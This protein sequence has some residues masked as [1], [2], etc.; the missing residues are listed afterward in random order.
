MTLYSL[1][2]FA[3]VAAAIGIFSGVCAWLYSAL[4]FARAERVEEVRP[5]ASLTAA[6]GNVVVACL[7]ILASAGFYMAWTVWGLWSGWVISATLAF[8]LLA[9]MGVLL[10]DPR[11]RAVSRLASA[12]PDG[13]LPDSL[14]QATQDP[15]LHIGLQ[16]YIFYLLGIVFLMTNKPDMFTCI[17]VMIVAS[18]VG[19][20]FGALTWWFGIRKRATAKLA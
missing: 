18:L 13:Q 19:I 1:V 15:V 4:V 8:G 12:S 14:R 5:V 10:I 2:L 17:V 16:T 20:G 7:P 3:H 9:P 11:M 6:A